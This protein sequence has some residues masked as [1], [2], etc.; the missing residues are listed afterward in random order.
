MAS[1][2]YL[3]THFPNQSISSLMHKLSLFHFVSPEPRAEP[4]HGAQFPEVS[5]RS[6]RAQWWIDCWIGLR[7]EGLGLGQVPLH[8]T[9]GNLVLRE[10]AD[11]AQ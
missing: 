6:T 1:L 2:T 10:A 8:L 4:A 7:V 11:G 9:L 5:V 3:L